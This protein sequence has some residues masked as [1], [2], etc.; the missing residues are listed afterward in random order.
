[1]VG[2]E[3]SYREL[4]HIYALPETGTIGE[5]KRGGKNEASN[6]GMDSRRSNL[7]RGYVIG[8]PRLHHH[9][10]SGELMRKLTQIVICSIVILSCLF[11]IWEFQMGAP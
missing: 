5:H 10:K 2:N 1:M 9:R 11:V 6:S 4:A 8:Q 3:Q 7:R